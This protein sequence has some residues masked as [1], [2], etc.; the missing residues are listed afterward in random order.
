MAPFTPN[1]EGQGICALHKRVG[2]IGP[3]RGGGGGIR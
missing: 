3:R 1:T 2:E